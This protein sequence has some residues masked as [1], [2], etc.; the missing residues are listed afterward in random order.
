MIDHLEGRN[1]AVPRAFKRNSAA[2][3][4]KNSVLVKNFDRTTITKYLLV[5]PA[6]LRNEIFEACHDEPSSWHL[7]NARTLTKIK[8]K[9]YWP[10]LTLDITHYIRSCRDCR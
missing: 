5:I 2:L 4:L 3:C 9:Y 10:R 1:V 8:M 6:V 7:G